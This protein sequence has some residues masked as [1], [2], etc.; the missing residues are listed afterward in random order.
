ME[1]INLEKIKSLGLLDKNFKRHF[2]DYYSSDISELDNL[3]KKVREGQIT[4]PIFQEKPKWTV[5]EA[6]STFN[7]ILANG[8][9]R[10]PFAFNVIT[11]KPKVK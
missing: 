11:D 6:I 3:C 5:Q 2:Q 8:F 1:N 10:L 4:A 9:F 7:F